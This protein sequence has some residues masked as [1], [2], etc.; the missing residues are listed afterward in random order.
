[1]R[2]LPL[3]GLQ[4]IYDI[5]PL[6]LSIAAKMR[7]PV[8]NLSIPWPRQYLLWMRQLFSGTLGPSFYYHQ[9]AAAVLYQSLG[10]SLVLV[11]IALLLTLAIGIPLGVYQALHR[12]SA[13]D[14]TTTGLAY[15]LMSTPP[16]VLS[17]LLLWI[18]AVMLRWVPAGGMRTILAPFSVWDVLR[19][20]FLPA[21]AIT[22]GN[23]AMYS[24][25]MRTAMLDQSAQLYIRTAHAK[26]VLPRRVNWRHVFP[27]A[28][29]PVLTILATNLSQ[30]LS[31]I[32]LIEIVF[33][34]PGLGVL[35]VD[36]IYTEDYN[37]LMAILV[38]SGIAVMMFN[39]LVDILYARI[40]P[41]IAYG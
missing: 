3:G 36:A 31:S 1:M 24:R 28:I 14:Y 38:I 37:V 6:T 9:S 5:P 2:S 22:L 4:Q 25:Y 10:A 32:F 11:A 18:F 41:R 12:D 34:W 23:I 8:W 40:D 15:V 27:N 19:H 21:L 26:G 33:N 30:I 7:N 29:M 35:F 17:L 20:L 39:L 16:Y 13:A